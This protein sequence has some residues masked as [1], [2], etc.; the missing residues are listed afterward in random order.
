LFGSKRGWLIGSACAAVLAML[1]LAYA[2]TTHDVVRGVT[3]ACVAIALASATND[4]ATDGYYIHAL[5]KNDQELFVGVRSAAWRLG[6]IAVMGAAV[7]VAGWLVE[8]HGF[9]RGRAWSLAFLACAAAYALGTLWHLVWLPRPA[10]DGPTRAG[11]GAWKAL[12]ESMREYVS[13]PGIVGALLF[14]LF[15]RAAESLLAKMIAPFLLA[16]LDAGGAG[17]LE[18]QVG[19]AYGTIGIVA[20]V[21]GGIL[22]GL[23]VSRFGLSRCL[24][25]MALAMHAPNLL[26][27][28]AAHTQPGL[29]GLVVVIGVEQFG[30]GLGLTAYLAALLTLSR[31]TPHSTTH[32]AISTGL[33]ALSAWIFGRYS[34]VLVEHLGFEHFFW[35]VSGVGLLGLA[36]LPL[37]PRE[38]GP[39]GAVL[40]SNEDSGR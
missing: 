38:S 23:V 30:Y 9:A 39:P 8:R 5:A 7:F 37:C 14:I 1:G 11:R 19:W 13:K 20:L 18:S 25:P 28:W 40:P 16:K 29:A 4:I 33:M 36:T 17:L 2:A 3:L 34:G 15:Y 21:V 24:W 6:L 10:S 27:V 31:G 26:Y 32:Y 12:A 35:L 22:G